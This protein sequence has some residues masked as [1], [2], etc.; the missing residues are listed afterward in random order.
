MLLHSVATSVYT[1]EDP[2]H[3]GFYFNLLAVDFQ[4]WKVY[5]LAATL[6][7]V[8]SIR[9]KEGLLYPNAFVYF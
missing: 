5:T 4:H 8:G 1:V 9:R 2:A 6:D 3:I 7:G